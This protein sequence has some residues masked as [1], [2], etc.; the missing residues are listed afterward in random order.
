[1]IIPILGI[2]SISILTA[3]ILDYLKSLNFDILSIYVLLG[4]SIVFVLNIVKFFLW[5]FLHKRYDL[6]STYPMTSIYFPLIYIISIIKGEVQISIL[7]FISMGLIFIGV[8]IIFKE[9]SKEII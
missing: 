4:I 2:V 9:D 1:M 7:S 6:S 5:N 8:Y 3:L